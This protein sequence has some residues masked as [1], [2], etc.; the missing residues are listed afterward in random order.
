MWKWIASIGKAAAI[1][2]IASFLSI[3]TTG[4]IVNSYIMT[5]V[6][7][8]KLPLEIQPVA[9][10]GVWGRLW[11]A[12]QV[13]AEEDGD[14]LTE[15]DAA[16]T[17]GSAGDRT[18]SEAGGADLSS[19][20]DHDDPAG[21]GA[22]S[23]DGAASEEPADGLG[24]PR[25]ENGGEAS[26]SEREGEQGGVEGEAGIG[27]QAQGDGAGANAPVAEP[28]AT[29]E[30]PRSTQSGGGEGASAD[31]GAARGEIE[32]TQLSDSSDDAQAAWTTET[33]MTEEELSEV[34]NELSA[35]DRDQLFSLLIGELP[36]S[37]W[38]EISTYMED[39]LT[40]EELQN[41]QQIVARYLD[42]AAYEELM[43]ILKKY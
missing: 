40:D 2:L 20:E 25:G 6:K 41:V 1:V 30:P 15:R 37:A 36:Q 18:S 24:D 22:P 33:A 8:Y 38:Q 9:L 31:A 17:G 12:E 19:G 42:E 27:S 3:W 4:Y 7:Q 28:D 10:S 26:S 43:G 5:I 39:G 16:E 13:T 29:G 23:G 11:G 21:S 14:L 32:D 35:S 34:K